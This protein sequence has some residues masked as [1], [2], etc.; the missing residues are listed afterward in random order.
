MSSN[1]VLL[2]QELLLEIIQFLDSESLRI[3]KNSC[4]PIFRI[5]NHPSFIRFIPKA[6][7]RN[8]E[9][10]AFTL[11]MHQEEVLT[12]TFDYSVVVSGL[13]GYINKFMGIRYESDQCL[14]SRLSIMTQSSIYNSDSLYFEIS[15]LESRV[16]GCMRVGVVSGGNDCFHPPGCSTGVGYNNEDGNLTLASHYG[17]SFQFGPPWSVNDTIGVGITR[18]KSVTLVYFTLNGNWIGEAPMDIDGTRLDYSGPWHAAFSSS[19]PCTVKINTGQESFLYKKVE[20]MHAL[21]SDTCRMESYYLPKISDPFQKPTVNDN[22]IRFPDN[23]YTVSRIVISNFP[24]SSFLYFEVKVLSHGPGINSFMS[25]GLSAKP[26]NPFHQVGWNRNTIGYHS[27]DGQ[28]Y[29]GSQQNG[30]QFGPAFT[31][32]D[33]IGCGYDISSESTYFTLNGNLLGK[34]KTSDSS[35]HAA[36]SAIRGWAL[37]VN[38]GEYPF[39]YNP[40]KVA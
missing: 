20:E 23:G 15:I 31:E 25:I 11:K 3:L 33:I 18:D 40:R 12:N 8:V 39:H 4:R 6:E 16:K 28:V 27:D 22:I 37:Q 13:N 14:F 5:I 7:I 10:D 26:T 21:L 17:D 1:L 29:I 32:N 34:F 24:V 2:P 35:L 19:G 38:F 30:I 36:V 9:V